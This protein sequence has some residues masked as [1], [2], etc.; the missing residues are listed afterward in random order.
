MNDRRIIAF[1]IVGILAIIFIACVYRWYLNSASYTSVEDYEKPKIDYS[2]LR[3]NSDD[4]ENAKWV[5][6]TEGFE[7]E[8]FKIVDV[9]SDEWYDGNPKI[10]LTDN[11]YYGD[12][13]LD[14]DEISISFPCTTKDLIDKGF[15]ISDAVADWN[16]GS[17]KVYSRPLT[18]SDDEDLYNIRFDFINHISGKETSMTDMNNIVV[19]AGDVIPYSERQDVKFLGCKVGDPISTVIEKYGVP[20]CV[21]Y[22]GHDWCEVTYMGDD[23]RYV[24]LTFGVNDYLSEF[25]LRFG[26]MSVNADSSKVLTIDTLRNKLRDML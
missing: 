19:G 17:D 24:S 11:C 1:T 4:L 12:L 10:L 9:Y 8:D 7:G 3:F 15:Y 21:Q 2:G 5:S 25:V 6:L 16:V 20:T 23:G 14:V 22:Y 13:T 18:Y 26:D